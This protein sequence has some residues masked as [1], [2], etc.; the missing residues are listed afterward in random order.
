MKTYLYDTHVHTAE[1][2]PC[3]KVSA[4]KLV[5]MY[6]I[7][8][9]HGIVITDHYFDEYF[10]SLNN[11]TWEDKVDSF[12][13]GYRL[14]RHEGEKIG[15]NVLLGMEIRFVENLNDYLV[16]GFDEEFLKGNK[17]LYKLNL[18]TFKRLSEDNGLLVFQAHPFRFWVTPANPLFLDGVEVYNGNPRHDSRNHLAQVFAGENNLLE[19]S[20]SDFHQKEDIKR[21]GIILSDAPSTSRELSELMVNGK[22][23][24]LIKAA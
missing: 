17:E 9:Y 11:K 12:L 19:I 18:K 4:L 7:A 8:G 3:G 20:G 23:L 22:V 1:T 13:R 5:Q 6:K 24:K 21:G 10:E 14:A 16:Y 15:L 2:S